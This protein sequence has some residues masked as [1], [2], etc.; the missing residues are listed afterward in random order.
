MNIK[1]NRVRKFT[2]RKGLILGEIASKDQNGPSEKRVG[3][4]K[5]GTKLPHSQ[6]QLSTKLS[7][8]QIIRMSRA[9][10][11]FLRSIESRT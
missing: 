9:I 4:K 8:A 1:T 7:I 3:R 11:S 5:S 2:F 10:F 6:T